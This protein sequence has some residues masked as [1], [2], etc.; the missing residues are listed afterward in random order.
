M[1]WRVIDVDFE[2]REKMIHENFSE[3]IRPNLLLHRRNFSSDPRL[4]VASVPSKNRILDT[5]KMPNLKHRVFTDVHTSGLSP[6]FSRA[7]SALAG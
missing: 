3:F 5:P 2:R 1:F 7:V 4:V 6:I